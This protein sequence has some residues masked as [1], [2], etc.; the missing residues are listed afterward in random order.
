MYFPPD[1]DRLNELK[2]QIDGGADFAELARDNSESETAGAGGDFGWVAKGQLDPSLIDAIFAA[3]LGK[4][5]PVVSVEGDGLYLFKA[6]TEEVRTPE[7]R[8]L[9]E[10]RSTAFSDWYTA[11]KD[12]IEIVRDESV[13]G[14]LG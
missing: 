3:E 5:T 14:T 7:G 8:Q 6:L 10:L 9:E 11:K 2:S 1:L 13:T 12:A 4:T